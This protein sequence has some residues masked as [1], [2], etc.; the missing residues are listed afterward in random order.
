MELNKQSQTLEV[1]V[2]I[3][4]DNMQEI[5]NDLNNAQHNK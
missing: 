5:L 1:E 3:L 2:G 4:Q